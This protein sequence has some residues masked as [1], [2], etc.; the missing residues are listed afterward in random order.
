M[1]GC[2]GWVM[3]RNANE[4][5][6]VPRGLLLS[7]D[8]QSV[9]Q[10]LIVSIDLR[11]QLWAGERGVEPPRRVVILMGDRCLSP[12]RMMLFKVAVDNVC[13]TTILGSCGVEMLRR[14]QCQG[15]HAKHRQG[16]DRSPEQSTRYHTSFSMSAGKREGQACASR[17]RG[18]MGCC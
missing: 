9:T 4:W 15:K 2:P 11:H 8:R 10:A 12:G 5:R 1:R 18:L 14:Q 3:D 16:C 7:R 6:N 13:V 17:G